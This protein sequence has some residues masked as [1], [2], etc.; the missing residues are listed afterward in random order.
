MAI[1]AGGIYASFLTYGKLHEQIF[2]FES[3]DGEKF[4]FA[5]FVLAIECTINVL[6]AA[7]PLMSSGVQKGLPIKLFIPAGISQ[8]LAKA[9]TSL[10][11]ANSLSFPVVTLAKS[12]KMVPVMIGSMIL[13]GKK[14][15]LKE[16]L[17]VGAIIAGTVIVTMTSKKSGKAEKEDSILGVVFILLSLAFDG[18]VGG[19]QTDIQN[20]T[21]KRLGKGSKVNQW[22]FMFFTNLFM[23]I[24]AICISFVPFRDTS[25][26]QT[27][28][29]FFLGLTYCMGNTDILV[30]ILLFSL[31]S[32]VGQSFIFFTISNFDSLTTT[33]VTTTRKVMSTLLSI[34]TEGHELS[35]TG[36][37]GIVLASCGIS[38]E[39][40]DKMGKGKKTEAKKE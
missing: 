35:P 32:A 11:L 9:C 20:E 10:A 17:S 14:Y 18:V 21:V 33:T 22:D 23:A 7:I 28:P 16:Y 27:T 4:K 25:F 31:A 5:F 39:I 30:K 24:T 26:T 19:T 13:G 3:A 6:F 29:E 1:G 36:W 37:G 15:T 8:V 38:M 34:F 2:K 40:V 12:G